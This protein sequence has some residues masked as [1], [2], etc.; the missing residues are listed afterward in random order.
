M[1]TKK[2][3]AKLSKKVTAKKTTRRTPVTTYVPVSNNIYFDGTSYRVRVINQ[4]VRTSR[5]FS[6]KRAAVTF[7]NKLMA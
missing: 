2:T 5:N 4:G 3:S 7:R 6:S 1:S